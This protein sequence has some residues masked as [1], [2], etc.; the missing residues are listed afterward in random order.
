[1]V[2]TI[3]AM[4]TSMFR[5]RGAMRSTGVGDS[6]VSSTMGCAFGHSTCPP[7]AR[8]SARF[9]GPM[10]I[11]HKIDAPASRMAMRA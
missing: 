5:A 8:F 4:G 3:T 10:S 9:M 2:S 1:M 6:T 11:F 7:A